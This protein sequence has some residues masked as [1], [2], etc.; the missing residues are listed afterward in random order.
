MFPLEGRYSLPA[1]HCI[2]I[3]LVIFLLAAV[4]TVP[5]PGRA[6]APPKG[7]A[8]L[9]GVKKSDRV[10]E[11]A[12]H[13]DGKP[14]A[15]FSLNLAPRTLRSNVTSIEV[16]A[17]SGPPGVWTTSPRDPAAAFLGVAA[18]KR[19]SLLI[20]AGGVVLNVPPEDAAHLLL[21]ASDDGRFSEPRRGYQ[22][23]VMHEDGATYTLP[24]RVNARTAAEAPASRPAGHGVRMSAVLK[25][26]SNF[27]AVN[28]G[29]E[30]KGD[31]KGDGL[32]V[33]TVEAAGKEI[34]GI[35]IQNTDGEPAVWDTVPGSKNAAIGVA[36]AS[37]PV[38]LL[39]RR[40]GSVNIPVKDRADLYLYVADN[41]SIS[42]GKTLY[43]VTITFADGG[44]SWCP[45]AKA[46][47][48][49]PTEPA[50]GPTPQPP[51]STAPPPQARPPVPPPPP[52][53]PEPK[54]Q[55]VTSVNFLATWLGFVST[56]AVGRYAELKPDSEADAV[57]GL[58]IDVSPRHAITGIEIQSLDDPQKKWKTGAAPGA[59]GLG[60]AYQSSP[61]SLLNNSDGSVRIDLDRREQFYL[62]AADSGN[63]ATT[64]HRMRMVVHLD[65]GSSYQQFVR[66]AHGTT[67]TVAPDPGAA[68]RARGIITCEFRGFIADLVN[69][70]TRPGKDGYLDGTFIMKLKAD[71]K[72][73]TSVEIKGTDGKVRWSSNPKAPAMFLG[74]SL[75]P[76]IYETINA[77][78][79]VMNLPV[80]GRKT[81]YLYGA[82]NGLLSDPNAKLI[83]EVTFSDKSTLSADVI[84]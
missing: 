6:Q 26:I 81:F 68:A 62:F 9:L 58:D 11:K 2:R 71:D 31:D 5:G 42:K 17:T 21:F 47:Q 76:K 18:A 84:K 65:D 64:Y 44:I 77:K 30:I 27:D 57:F 15:V 54:P 79:G 37:D 63:L 50:P 8:A 52:P 36:Y 72:T 78:G 40:N 25:G 4:V 83:A 45:A 48:E 60:V 51:A 38:K 73:L 43:R 75:Y 70:S 29:K 35:Q 16:R 56:D 74:V 33:L 67:P 46:S 32:F 41:G 34:S 10:G 3:M 61:K 39:N 49:A 53:T 82:D 24:V 1:L 69:T 59:W 55:V 22:V 13:P 19:P 23:R 12:P 80:S 28:P 14:D 7:D 66:T 20:N